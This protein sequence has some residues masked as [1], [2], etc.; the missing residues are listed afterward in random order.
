[1]S[2]SRKVAIVTGAGSGIG[3]AVALT[4][5]QNGFAVSLAGRRIEALNETIGLAGDLSEFALA[6]ATDVTNAD[7]VQALFYETLAAFNRIDVLFNNA[8]I[9]A[10]GALLEDVTVEEWRQIVDVNLTGAFLCTQSAF[11][12][13]KRQ[14]PMGGRIINNG[15]ISA[16]SPRPN[17]ASYSATKH[18]IT[19]LTKSTSLDGRK[20]NIA[21]GQIDIGNAS[22][23]MTSKMSAGVPQADGTIATEPTIDVQHVGDAVLYMANLPLVANVQFMTVMA[24][25]MPF[26]GRG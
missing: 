10:S 8:G 2:D 20:Y 26:I 9:G 18:A 23:D 1:M 5:L 14:N 13:M 16:T 22:T 24:S 19:G 11:R 7:S 6:T 15:S 4:L 3:R 17:S 21:C 12:Y 25:K